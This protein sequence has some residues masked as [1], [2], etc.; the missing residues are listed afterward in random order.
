MVQRLST[1]GGPGRS[2]FKPLVCHR[3]PL[4]LWADHLALLPASLPRT[5]Y[6]NDTP[7]PGSKQ[8]KDCKLIPYASKILKKAT[9]YGCHQ[10][11]GRRGVKRGD[12][13]TT[14]CALLAADKKAFSSC[15]NTQTD[16]CRTDVLIDSLFTFEDLFLAFKKTAYWINW[17]QS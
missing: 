8:I 11:A 16:P 5:H 17:V 6:A 15:Q 3:F 14:V 10:T 9:G 7:L 2:K 13:L 1:S 4:G 12:S